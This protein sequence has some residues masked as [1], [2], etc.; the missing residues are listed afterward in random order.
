[1]VNETKL[2]DLRDLVTNLVARDVL[3]PAAAQ[4]LKELSRALRWFNKEHVEQAAEGVIVSEVLADQH[5][6]TE[7]LKVKA[8]MQSKHDGILK[9]FLAQNDWSVVEAHILSFVTA[10]QKTSSSLSMA[11]EMW[12]RFKRGE[13]RGH[14]M[15]TRFR[16]SFTDA[17][18][19]ARSSETM[20]RLSSGLASLLANM[21]Q[22]L[23]NT[24][25]DI[26][27]A[28]IKAFGSPMADVQESVGTV[29]AM[30]K[31]LRQV[32]AMPSDV[33]TEMDLAVF[34]T[35]SGQDFKPDLDNM[36][37]MLLKL[38]AGLLVLQQ[39]QKILALSGSCRGGEVETLISFFYKLDTAVQQW[40][41]TSEEYRDAYSNFQGAFSAKKVAGPQLRKCVEDLKVDGLI[42]PPKTQ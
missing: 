41:A 10:A 9:G 40:G 11:I 4:E 25:T 39:I 28:I 35:G 31:D 42:L 38:E 26:D 17:V 2:R 7:A 1:M 21:N 16:A 22:A 33:L 24:Q 12:D 6:A 34:S 27:N 19:S 32:I 14:E 15:M 20:V 8:G 5:E 30:L 36:N 18:E 3:S 29:T 23:E 13:D 37:K